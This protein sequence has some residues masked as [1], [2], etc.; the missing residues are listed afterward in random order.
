MPNLNLAVGIHGCACN[1]N[2]SSP[3]GPKAYLKNIPVFQR[4]QASFQSLLSRTAHQYFASNNLFKY[5]KISKLF[6]FIHKQTLVI[7]IYK[8]NLYRNRSIYK[9]SLLIPPYA[10]IKHLSRT[11]E[12]RLDLGG[13][14]LRYGNHCFQNYPGND[15]CLLFRKSLFQKTIGVA[16]SKQLQGNVSCN[17]CPAKKKI[18]IVN[19]KIYLADNIFD[20]Y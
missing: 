12:C 3:D 10:M 5:M 19:N 6:L 18:Y 15:T 2:I 8:R 13:T 4:Q 16:G 14:R 7:Y 9:A 11:S 17:S 1:L 20:S